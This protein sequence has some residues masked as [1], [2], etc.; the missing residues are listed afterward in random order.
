MVGDGGGGGGRTCPPAPV[1]RNSTGR[2]KIK[3]LQKINPC[4]K[5]LG[6]PIEDLKAGTYIPSCLKVYKIHVYVESP[7]WTM[8]KI[9][10]TAIICTGAVRKLLKLNSLAYVLK[11]KSKK[12]LFKPNVFTSLLVC[13]HLNIHFFFQNLMQVDIMVNSGFLHPFLK[14]HETIK[15]L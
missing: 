12:Y 9:Q 5:N 8:N 3:I 10:C 14:L 15:I 2:V 1:V 7:K 11:R 13:E 6:T 4:E